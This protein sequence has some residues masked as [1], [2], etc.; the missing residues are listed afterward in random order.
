MSSPSSPAY[1]TCTHSLFLGIVRSWRHQ[2]GM[3]AATARDST[4]GKK[5]P[6]PF[7]SCNPGQGVFF[8]G[9]VNRQTP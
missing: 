5:E 4:K 8:E 6:G 2:L 1:T 3:N 7:L 9:G